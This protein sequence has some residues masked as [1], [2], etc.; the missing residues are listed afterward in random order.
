MPQVFIWIGIVLLQLKK[1][2]ALSVL[3]CPGACVLPPTREDDAGVP[4]SAWLL[5]RSTRIDTFLET[6]NNGSLRQGLACC[7]GKE[8]AQLSHGVAFLSA[9]S[10]F[11]NKQSPRAAV[12]QSLLPTDSLSD[13]S[14]LPLVI[15]RQMLH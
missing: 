4:V 13:T 3:E 5:L 10:N 14:E 11:C 1:P 12:L 7:S 9:M 6:T 15:F 8:F 2:S